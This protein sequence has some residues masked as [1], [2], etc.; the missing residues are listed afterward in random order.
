MRLIGLPR[1][2]RR[3]LK[4]GQ[5]LRRLLREKL[6]IFRDSTGTKKLVNWVML[7]T[8]GLASNAYSLG[9]V[10]QSLDLKVLFE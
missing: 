10:A 4:A 3:F 7:S 2:F 5:R 6:R 9:A 8:F 1:V